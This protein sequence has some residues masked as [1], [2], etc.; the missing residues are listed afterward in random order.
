MSLEENTSILKLNKKLQS[1]GFIWYKYDHFGT[2]FGNLR[3]LIRLI[4][5]SFRAELHTVVKG[6]VESAKL[7]IL[8][9]NS[10]KTTKSK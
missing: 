9:H 5:F 4:L 8:C 10:Y 2:I 6:G 1:F 3:T 7:T